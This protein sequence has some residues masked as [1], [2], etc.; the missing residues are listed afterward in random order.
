MIRK[1]ECNWIEPFYHF[2]VISDA[3]SG[4]KGVVAIS[5]D[6]KYKIK[7]S[8]ADSTV[9]MLFP[10]AGSVPKTFILPFLIDFESVGYF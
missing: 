7:L 1:L 3:R 9:Q 10:G 5:D 6:K 8:F 2:D 4:L